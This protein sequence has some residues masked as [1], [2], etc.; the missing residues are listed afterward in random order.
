M[1]A[2]KTD[3]RSKETPLPVR[4]YRSTWFSLRTGKLYRQ[5]THPVGNNWVLEVTGVPT[6]AQVLESGNVMENLQQIESENG[7][8]WMYVHDLVAAFGFDDKNI[9]IT[10]TGLSI[11]NGLDQPVTID[12]LTNRITLNTLEVFIDDTAAGVGGLTA[13]QIYQ[14]P[15]GELRIKL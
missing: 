5:T 6:L 9:S 7:S 1:R 4:A 3:D 8:A 2:Y 10:A 14:T 11:N 13:K 15:T 12:W